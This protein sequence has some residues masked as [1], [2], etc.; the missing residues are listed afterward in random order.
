VLDRR[1]QRDPT[2]LV[3]YPFFENCRAGG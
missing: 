2:D 3:N 1:L